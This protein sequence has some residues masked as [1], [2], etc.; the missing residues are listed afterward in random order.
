MKDFYGHI[1]QGTLAKL[2]WSVGLQCV[3]KIFAETPDFRIKA[4]P[5]H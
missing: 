4:R 1:L 3:K 5:Q 2:H